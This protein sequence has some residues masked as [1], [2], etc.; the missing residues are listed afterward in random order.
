VTNLISSGPAIAARTALRRN[1]AIHG[2]IVRILTRTRPGKG[3][4]E[5]FGKAMFDCIRPGDCV[6]DVGAN[7]GLYS[8]LFAEAVGPT[9][10]VISF[11]PAPDSVAAIE[12]RRSGNAAGAS[13]QIVTGAL[14]N[15]DGQAWLSVAS[16]STAPDNRLA[17][18]AGS[19]TVP[20][21]TFR[22]DSV[23]ASGHPSPS[24]I[25]I[26]VE[27]FEG[28]V[29][30][31]LGDLLTQPSLRAICA[32]IH[33]GILSERGKPGEPGRLVQLLKNL[34]FSVSW[35]DRSHLIAQR[36]DA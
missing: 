29:I 20:V 8:E 30:D 19:A 7:V 31:G 27:G 2:A 11:E 28:E 22:G 9:G 36:K 10:T 18:G 34:G 16:G 12:A 26:D 6:W 17:D 3:Y 13:W 23:V 24:V 1:P 32:E 25:K 4:E 35:P 33:F 5:N 15:Q 21:R 14:S